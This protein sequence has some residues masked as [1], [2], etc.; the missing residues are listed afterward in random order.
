MA[1]IKEIKEGMM[2]T[3]VAEVIKDNFEYL[4]VSKAD[5]KK[6]EEKLS[7]QRNDFEA[8]KF[9]FN[10][11][12]YGEHGGVHNLLSAI[13]DVPKK[14]R[15]LGQKITFRTE[16]GDWATYHNESLSL[17]N[18][19]NTKDWV[20][21][22]G[23]KEV[24]GDV[25]IE[26]APDYEDLTEAGNGTIKFADKEYSK[27]SFSGLGRIYL[28]K[29]IVN[30]V[31][32]LQ[33]DHVLKSNTIYI[34][35]YDYNLNGATIEVPEGC[36]LDFQ[37]GS[38]SN[39]TI[40]GKNTSINAIPVEIFKDNVTIEGT[41]NVS[42]AY[43]EWF[44]AKGDG[45]TDDV[46]AIQ[47]TVN[48][49]STVTMLNKSY[50][51][52]KI[53]D[54]G[55][56]IVVPKGRI[57][58]GSKALQTSTDL[59]STITYNGESKPTSVIE[60]NEGVTLSN[61]S[62]TGY[63]SLSSSTN[64]KDY[65]V[66]I[67]SVGTSFVSKLFFDNIQTQRGDIGF[68]LQ[69][70]LSTFKGCQA[71][72]NNIGFYI[73]GRL[74][75]AEIPQVEGTSITMMNCYCIN[76]HINAFRV[77][78][79]TYSTFINLAADSC[80][81][82]FNTK[83]TKESDINYPYI[84]RYL[85]ATKI[86]NCGA[87]VSLKYMAC[88]TCQ[89]VSIDHCH[90]SIGWHTENMYNADYMP[91][92][93]IAFTYS[94]NIRLVDFNFNIGGLHTSEMSSILKNTANLGLFY[95]ED[96]ARE[97]IRYHFYGG[98]NEYHNYNNNIV[99]AGSALRKNVFIEDTV[100][101]SNSYTYNSGSLYSI[102]TSK[103]ISDNPNQSI[104]ITMNHTS[105]IELSYVKTP[106]DL[107]GKTINIYGDNKTATAVGQPGLYIKN[108][109]L[110]FKGISFTASDS[111]E[112]E[113]LFH[114]TNARI[115]LDSCAIYNI[116][117]NY[118]SGYICAMNSA[119]SYITL[120]NTA[121]RGIELS[122]APKGQ[123]TDIKENFPEYNNNYMTFDGSIVHSKGFTYNAVGNGKSRLSCSIR[124]V[125]SLPE[126]LA[127]NSYNWSYAMTGV[128][129]FYQGKLVTFN[130]E[131]WVDSSGTPIAE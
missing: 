99:Y 9:G 19:E 82:D 100:V 22:V 105:G 17:A 63:L 8:N 122:L 121:C 69:T 31:N 103:E 114:C 53:N 11:T 57:L 97:N 108:G 67:K 123:Y 44:G 21:E 38:I 18:Y 127:D 131:N 109:S 61:F 75:N 113:A 7:E 25:N 112:R 5:K 118:T 96:A 32:L 90:F 126:R 119:D 56:C 81:H 64:I 24:T 60:V 73:H 89:N 130:G 47:R 37:G 15:M 83:V 49:F 58:R 128:T 88:S 12:V 124:Y 74:D 51:V 120:I 16:N 26:N 117:T 20:Q 52:S 43:P 6:T 48:S 29:N 116:G 3:E 92:K 10:V 28:R 84:F 91:T 59:N 71:H 50:A 1:Q 2:A 85:R 55:T 94:N 4:S 129:F 14:Y 93:I 102:L 65:S 86:Q 115:I 98:N 39:G 62:V 125:D 23:I 95:I 13:K 34:V 110:N 77:V 107:K 101:Y 80:G 70:Y 106:I 40:I 35:Q 104:D 30:G 87:E 46:D 111:R 66:C 36:M 78:G 79:I 42:E 72:N 33:Q 27:T 68:N 45:E 41:W 76:S 54:S